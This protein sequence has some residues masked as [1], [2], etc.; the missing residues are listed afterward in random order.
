MLLISDLKCILSYHV[1][2]PSITSTIRWCRCLVADESR[3][4]PSYR[5]PAR[6]G[7]PQDPVLLAV[8]G[9]GEFGAGLLRGPSSREDVGRTER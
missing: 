5:Q 2:T 1:V 4:E 8:D 3:P 9:P 7:R 6:P